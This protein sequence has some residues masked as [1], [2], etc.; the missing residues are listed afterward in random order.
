MTQE[1][2]LTPKGS[3]DREIGQIQE[4]LKNIEKTLD[5]TK[6]TMRDFTKF[7][8]DS[9]ADRIELKDSTAS[10]TTTVNDHLLDHKAQSR[11]M[12]R[13]IAIIVAVIT[14]VAQLLEAVGVLVRA[15]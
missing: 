3:Y 6:L 11:R 12:Y 5:E 4:S 14:A 9:T 8:A 7:V 2:P 15:R 1:A 13:N 10:L